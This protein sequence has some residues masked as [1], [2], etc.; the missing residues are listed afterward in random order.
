MKKIHFSELVFRICK[1]KAEGH[2]KPQSNDLR[3]LLLLG[4]GLEEEW[5]PVAPGSTGPLV[6]GTVLL[7][8]LWCCHVSPADSALN[9]LLST[10]IAISIA[11]S[12][13]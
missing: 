3:E 6:I 12:A 11:T 9:I 13:G 5:N 1:V 4:W 8:Q 7:R 2:L 10:T